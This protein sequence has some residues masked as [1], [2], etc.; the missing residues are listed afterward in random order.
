MNDLKDRNLV[1]LFR[2]NS[3]QWN[4]FFKNKNNVI[5]YI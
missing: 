5:L 3:N 4:E 2:N 1:K